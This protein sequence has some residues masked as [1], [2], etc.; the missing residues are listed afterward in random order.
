MSSGDGDSSLLVSEG[1]CPSGLWCPLC[2]VD[3]GVSLGHCCC[4][5][6]SLS[7]FLSSYIALLLSIDDF[8]FL[9]KT[10]G[11]G[12][13]S[14][15]S[16]FSFPHGVSLSGQIDFI[17]MSHTK[18]WRVWVSPWAGPIRLPSLCCACRISPGPRPGTGSPACG[19]CQLE[20]G[21]Q[22]PACLTTERLPWAMS[23][24]WLRHHV[25]FLLQVQRF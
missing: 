20:W 2:S 24:S 18:L 15:N 21:T 11:V 17:F 14:Q 13:C 9:M 8:T 16:G 12:T 10:M 22:T 5:A 3:T 1:C 25:G 6:T 19:S 4:H 23:L 7:R